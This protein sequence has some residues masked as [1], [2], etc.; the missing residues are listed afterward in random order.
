LNVVL[1]V[2]LNLM[3]SDNFRLD[4]IATE[5]LDVCTFSMVIVTEAKIWVSL[6]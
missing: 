3:V 1:N 5:N 4:L 6:A 2:K